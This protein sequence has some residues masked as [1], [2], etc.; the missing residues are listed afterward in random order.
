MVGELPSGGGPQGARPSPAPEVTCQSHSTWSARGP[1]KPMIGMNSK[2]LVGTQAQ[3]GRRRRAPRA[4]PG[5]RAGRAGRRG[6]GGGR[7]RTTGARGR[8][9]RWMSNRSGSAKTLGSRLAA[10]MQTRT[11][12][13]AGSSTPLSV[14]RPRRAPAPVDRPTSRSAAPPRPRRGSATGRRRQRSQPSPVLEQP[15]QRRCRAGW[16]SSRGRRAGARTGSSPPPA[17]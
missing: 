11:S 1:R 15:A 14:D 9:R 7:S 2:R 17:G 4:R 10:P 3:D 5:P 12:A 6:R 13:S 16:S 8:W